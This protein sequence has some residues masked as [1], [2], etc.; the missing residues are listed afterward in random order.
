[1]RLIDTLR[2]AGA[3]LKTNKRRSMLTMLGLI[4]GV[5]AVILVTS[6]GAGAQSL[7]T[8]QFEKRGTN[9][10][11]IM[12]GAT[13]EN[14]PPAAVLGI[15]ITTLTEEDME[16]IRDSRDVH[17]ILNVNAYAS[18]NDLLVW[19]SF[20]RHVTYTGT[21]HTYDEVENIAVANGRFFDEVEEENADAVMVLGSQ[22]AED[23]FGNQNPVGQLVKLRKKQFRVIGV[24][25][26]KGSTGFENPDTDI[27]IP[28]KSAQKDLLGISH[29]SFIRLRVDDE[30]YID[31]T[32]DEIRALL[33]ERHDD[34]DF[35][36]ENTADVLETLT[37]VTNAIKFFL[38]AVAGVSLF[39]GG[40]GIMNIMLIAVKEKTKEVG[41]RKAVGAK[42]S[43]VARQ[44]LLESTLLS[45]GGGAIGIIIGI[46]LAYLIS[47]IV[48][49]LEYDYAFIVS[50]YSILAGVVVS[51]AIGMIFGTIPARQA[52]KLSPM[53]ALRYE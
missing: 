2:V 16:A 36:V 9:M 50:P 44:F 20:E 4:I 30:A 26:A 13:E 10:M 12:P 39:V 18:G 23:I 28:L 43:D 33:T 14:G 46:L 6:L 47:L 8:S 27:L 24:L 15:I 5:T 49:A 32:A 53:E 7:I 42:N 19:E 40:V 11:A 48:N 22:I 37:T 38:V 17:H 3:S 21:T 31:Q 1:M 41:L 34:E 25:E 29:V 52:A 51:G 35:S 45:L